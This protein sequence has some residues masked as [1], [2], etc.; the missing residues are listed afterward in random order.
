MPIAAENV[1]ESEDIRRSEEMI[2]GRLIPS[3]A[4]S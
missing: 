1:L 4:D 3:S 2:F